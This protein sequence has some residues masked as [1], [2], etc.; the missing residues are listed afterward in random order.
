MSE[1]E[2]RGHQARAGEEAVLDRAMAGLDRLHQQAAYLTWTASCPDVLLATLALQA[3]LRRLQP[4]SLTAVRL[5]LI[6]AGWARALA[7]AAPELVPIM[8]EGTAGAGAVPD[9]P[10]WELDYADL[11]GGCYLP[12]DSEIGGES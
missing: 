2:R 1:R 5:G 10:P 9:D 12:T 6:V 3:A 4:G 7:D 11:E 8:E